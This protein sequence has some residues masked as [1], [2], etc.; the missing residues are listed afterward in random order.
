MIDLFI[1]SIASLVG[2]A[3]GFIYRKFRRGNFWT[4]KCGRKRFKKPD[5]NLNSDD[6][7]DILSFNL[8]LS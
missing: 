8:N 3:I 6:Q 4:K 7:R 5:P 1:I 2:A